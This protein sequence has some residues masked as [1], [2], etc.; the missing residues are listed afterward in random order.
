MKLFPLVRPPQYP[1]PCALLL[2]ALGGVGAFA[3]TVEGNALKTFTVTPG[4]RLVVD[5]DRGSIEVTS[6]KGTE[7]RVEVF[8]KSTALTE[9]RAQEALDEHTLTLDQDGNT[10][11]VRGR[12]KRQGFNWSLW[13]SDHRRFEVRY[14]IS[15]PEKFDVDLKTGGGGITVSDLTGDVRLRTS[16][17][18]LRIGRIRGPVDAHTSGG[19]I[20]LAGCQGRARIET[21]GGG[22]EIG[23]GEG[24]VSAD[25][26]GGSIHIKAYKGD[27]TAHTS[28]GGITVEQ[29]LGNIDASTSGGSISAVLAAQP[30]GDCRLA[31]SG[32]GIT[33]KV[34]ESA[35]LNIDAE[36][37]GGGVHTDLP[38][39][40]TIIGQQR[41]NVLKGKLN[42]GG[43][44]LVLRTSGGSI[45]LERL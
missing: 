40:T 27:V 17:G 23:E 7:V 16:G 41:H 14:V 34:L 6:G 28:G 20:H 42:S 38:V 21:S 43:K 13:S 4:G 15:V 30:T 36:T 39:T 3:A 44:E 11:T 25:T 8:R 32:G 37:S 1:L 31:T 12:G 22:I 29:A 35:A 10:V 24:T 45:H 2:L 18:G 9:S 19:S 26:S 5:S 33:V